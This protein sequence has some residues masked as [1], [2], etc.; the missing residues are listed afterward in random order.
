MK[1]MIVLSGPPGSGK[2]TQAELLCQRTGFAHFST[3]D[4]FRFEI[5][6]Q[7]EIGK[8]VN[9][10]VKQGTLVPDPIVLAVTKN[11]INHNQD[12][13]VVFDGFPRT[14]VQAQGLDEVLND[15][16][17][18]V[19]CAI[20]IELALAEIIRRLTDRRVCRNCGAIYNLS[21][22]HPKQEGICDACNG[23][24]YQRLD[25]QE[26]T[27]RKRHQVYEQQT[28]ELIS[29]YRSHNKLW[30]IPGEIGK[31]LVHERIMKIVYEA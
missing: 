7:T 24:L 31:D 21:F 18:E 16:H 28:Q 14:M 11:F 9:E 6:Q 20:F 5:A 19:D 26:P 23:E 8:K 17:K 29:Y 12:K 25:D 15:N 22:K 13:G 1:R 27:I 2:G 30:T 4:Q 10:Y 3:G